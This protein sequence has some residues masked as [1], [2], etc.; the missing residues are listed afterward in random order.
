MRVAVRAA[1]EGKQLLM[2][3]QSS[4][5]RRSPLTAGDVRASGSAC[6]QQA[7]L[8]L[9][10]AEGNGRPCWR[11]TEPSTWLP[12][13]Q[14]MRTTVERC[15]LAGYCEDSSMCNRFAHAANQDAVCSAVCKW[16]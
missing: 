9:C 13:L 5:P 6:G 1:R 4:I 2:D 7:G 11:R 3:A 10:G 15:A 12:T 16:F 14:V 8:N